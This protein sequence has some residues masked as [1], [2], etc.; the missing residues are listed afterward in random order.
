VKAHACRG[1]IAW[2]LKLVIE[3]QSIPSHLSITP[4]MM[5]ARHVL[6]VCT[7][8]SHQSPEGL[9]RVEENQKLGLQASL[10]IAWS[11]CLP[12]PQLHSYIP[13]ASNLRV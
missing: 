2:V 8:C 10:P 3:A 13:T 6:P 4:D 12:G 7:S 9:A 11:S 1:S 5:M